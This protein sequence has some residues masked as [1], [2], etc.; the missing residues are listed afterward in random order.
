[1]PAGMQAFMTKLRARA[2]MPARCLELT[3]LTAARASE[4]LGARW[5][6]IDLERRL[7]T[8]PAE[9][10]KKRKEHRVALSDAAIAL[11]AGLPRDGELVFPGSRGKMTGPR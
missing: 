8:V 3:I 11:L 2:G 9:R 1:P 6:E 5:D 10:M 7:W 4:A